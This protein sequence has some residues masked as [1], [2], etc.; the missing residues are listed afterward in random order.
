[1]IDDY[2]EQRQARNPRHTILPK[3]KLLQQ[4]G[5]LSDDLTPTVSGMLLF[6]KEPQ[7]FLPQSRAIFVKFADTGPRGP[8]G[9]FGYGRREEFIGPLPRHHRPRLARDLG[10]DGQ[11]LPSCAACSARKRPSIPPRPC[12]R[13]WSMPSPTATTG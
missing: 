8:E 10:R 3:D 4:I 7:L 9:S 6:G 5:A 13:R 12:A 2:L 1:M 11:A